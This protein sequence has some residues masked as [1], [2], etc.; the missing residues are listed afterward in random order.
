MFWWR[1][2]PWMFKLSVWYNGARST[3]RRGW[4]GGCVCVYVCFVCVC[5]C[6]GDLK[7]CEIED[8]DQERWEEEGGVETW[9]EIELGVDWQRRCSNIIFLS[10]NFPLSL[11]LF[12][13]CFLCIPVFPSCYLWPNIFMLISLSWIIVAWLLFPSLADFKAHT[14]FHFSWLS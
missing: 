2:I 8:R 3:S 1:H 12:I 13:P 4:V 5:S 10:F 14:C 7:P 9:W 11:S 6:R